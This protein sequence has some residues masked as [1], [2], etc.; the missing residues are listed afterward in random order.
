MTI[1]SRLRRLI[2]TGRARPVRVVTDSTADLPRETVEELAITV[3]PLQIT[4]GEESFRDGVDLT[5]EEFFRRLPDAADLPQTSQPS[6]GEFQQAYEALLTQTDR[7]LSIHLSSHFSGT[8]ATARQAAHALAERGPIEVI[9]SDT[10]SM[11]MG[12]AVIAAA[13]AALEGADLPTCAEAARSVL[14]RERLAIAF[15]TLEYLRRGGRIGRAEAFLGGLLRLKPILTIRD[16]EAFPLTRVRTRA[17]ALQEVL[18]ICLEDGPPIEAAVM[19]ATTPEDA[20]LLVDELLQRHPDVKVQT[21]RFG[22]ALGVHGGP[23]LIGLVVVLAEQRADQ[24]ASP[25]E[26]QA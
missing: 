22:P 11:P 9:D 5:N 25:D 1:F 23:G 18:R 26:T 4:F 19:H 3:V 7:I 20:R 21:G 17:K 12:L 16:G 24:T 8:V 14:R 6:V 13:S 15:D 10:V 2:P